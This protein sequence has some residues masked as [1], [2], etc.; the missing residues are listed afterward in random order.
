AGRGAEAAQAYLSAALA[1]GPVLSVELH[2]RAAWQFYVS[3]HMEDGARVLRGVLDKLGLQMPA[4]A[5]A[6][7]L[8]LLV[9]RLRIRLRGL[10]FQEKHE[11]EVRSQDLLRIDTCWA[12]GVGVATLDMV[13]GADFQARHLLL[14]LRAGEP[15]RIARALAIE[16]CYVAM[17]GNK[18]LRRA[19]RLIEASRTLAE[20]V[21]HPYALGLA[22]LAAGCA[23]WLDGRWRESR[24]LSARA[25]QILR[26]RCTGVD[27]EI[28]IA[29]LFG[30]ASLFFLGDL[31]TLSR[32]LPPLL[33]EAE[34]RNNLLRATV[35]RV[36][37]FS[38]VPWLAADDPARALQEMEDGLSGWRRGQFDY[39]Q[40]WV[41]A[42]RTEIALYRGEPPAASAPV[43]KPWRAFA[44]ALDRFVQV[45]Y[46]RGLDTRARLRLG[47][48]A[49]VEDARER[50]ALVDGVERHARAI[51]RERTRW[52]DP[53][54][55]ILRAGAAATAGDAERALRSLE[56]AEAGFTTAE[57]ALHAAAARRRRGELVGGDVGR[58]LVASVDAW[59]AGQ[60]VRNPERMTAMLAP[61]RW[62]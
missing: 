20:R 50:H 3:G 12:V 9:R 59:M 53:L 24:S 16:G 18:S 45:G 22:T 8:W 60:S 58:D 34:G 25:E 4:T 10:A 32:R 33:E 37:F 47:T 28:L 36:G 19:G 29:Q 54:A 27:W 62:R 40:L 14:A 52:G 30:L 6:A 11:S 57:M 51:L 46:I 43:P 23:A 2:R 48:A 38:H 35:L 7:L 15:Y 17:R 21:K 13:R 26:E 1:A 42:A 56:A 61:G 5:Q 49:H 41:R 55:W 44:R 39:L 31:A